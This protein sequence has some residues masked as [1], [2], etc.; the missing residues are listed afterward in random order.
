MINNMLTIGMIPSLFTDEEK[1][2]VINKVRNAAKAEGF[3]VT[4]FVF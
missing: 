1:D 2:E 3:G 4:K